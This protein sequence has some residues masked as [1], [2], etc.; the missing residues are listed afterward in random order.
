M[1][2][3][4]DGL[5]QDFGSPGNCACPY[6]AQ[7]CPAGFR[8]AIASG[9]R[10]DTHS[11]LCTAFPE[12]RGGQLPPLKCWW[13]WGV[14]QLYHLDFDVSLS[15]QKTEDASIDNNSLYVNL[16]FFFAYFSILYST[17]QLEIIPAALQDLRALFSP[18]AF[19]FLT[20]C[21]SLQSNKGAT[22]MKPHKPAI[23]LTNWWLHSW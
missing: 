13:W 21:P 20:F 9:R 18:P 23:S 16:C 22:S 1:P 10:Q 8:A 11:A 7:D 14:R 15:R 19:C 5:L 4:K 3:C 6:Q 2:F 12:G 17:S